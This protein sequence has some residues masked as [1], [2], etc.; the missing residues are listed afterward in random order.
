MY[1]TSYFP[2]TT[3]NNSVWSSEKLLGNKRQL[4]IDTKWFEIKKIQMS[5]QALLKF[6]KLEKYPLAHLSFNYLCINWV[7]T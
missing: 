2:M 4:K 7:C 6:G 1:D 5:F 3:F